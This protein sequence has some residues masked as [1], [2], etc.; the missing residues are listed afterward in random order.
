[1]ST[2]EIAA[3]WANYCNTGQSEKA[4]QELYHQDC[5]SVEMPGAQGYPE[6]AEGMAAIM[7]KGKQWG[8]MIETFHAMEIEGPIVAGNYFTATMKMDIT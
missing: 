2:Q 6:R 5:I 4:Y 8:E 3:K 1:M 7:E